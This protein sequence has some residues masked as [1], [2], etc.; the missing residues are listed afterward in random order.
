MEFPGH[1]F[2]EPS[3]QLPKPLSASD[4][5]GAEV[6]SV[7]PRGEVA[8]PAKVPIGSNEDEAWS[9]TQS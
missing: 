1:V 8:S 9:S 6:S 7:T 5:F 4:C 2:R 3:G